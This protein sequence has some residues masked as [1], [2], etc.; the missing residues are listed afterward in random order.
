MRGQK[1]HLPLK[2]YPSKQLAAR[3]AFP[4]SL[5]S[6]VISR[7]TPLKLQLC[8]PLSSKSPDNPEP[9]NFLTIPH[10]QPR[11]SHFHPS[12][13]STHLPPI[14]CIFRISPAVMAS[15]ASETLLRR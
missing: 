8:G 3:S 7:L 13:T 2:A 6:Y 5:G 11:Q 10:H 12:A 14:F 1:L 4:F 15:L 9:R